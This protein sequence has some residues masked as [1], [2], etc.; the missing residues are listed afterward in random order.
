[1]KQKFLAFKKRVLTFFHKAGRNFLYFLIAFTT[2]F[3]IMTAIIIQVIQAGVYR[4]TDADLM[5]RKDN[6]VELSLIGT[7]SLGYEN[8]NKLPSD[9]LNQ[10]IIEKNPLP[11]NSNSYHQLKNAGFYVIL[12]DENGL[13]LNTEI[14]PM[15]SLMQENELEMDISAL[16]TVTSQNVENQAFRTVISKVEKENQITINGTKI[17]Y[18]QI[19]QNVNQIRDSLS[20]IMTEIIITMLVFWILSLFFAIG[21]SRLSIHPLELALE[22]QKAFVSNASHEL[23][24]PLA[25]MQNRLQLLFQHPDATILE[26]SEHISASLN[27]V[28][29]MRVLT[30][31]LLNMAKSDGSVRIQPVET[32]ISFFEEVFDNFKILSKE[33][34][35]RFTSQIQLKGKLNLDQELIKQILVIFYDNAVKYTDDKGEISIRVQKQRNDLLLI[36]SDNG[37][38]VSAADKKKIFD[39]FYRVDEV[40]TRGKGGL[41]LGLSLVQEI[42]YAMRGKIFVEDNQPKGTKFIVKL[43]I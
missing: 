1:M 15:A 37:I 14:D 10:S 28:R 19:F 16:E 5:M 42:V 21:L 29:N 33:K 9:D 27:E 2:I 34:N 20:T 18:I 31:N 3:V 13:I 17:A 6:S 11:E 22:R 36:I 7:N 4:T 24:T 26:E 43:K 25:I 12:F 8:S 35:K 40:R 39:R 32:D 41:G 23:R 30:K 38:G